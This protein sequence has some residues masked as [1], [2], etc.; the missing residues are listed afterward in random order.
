M[1]MKNFQQYKY[2]AALCF[3]GILTL[4]A[5]SP[6]HAEVVIKLGTLAPDGSPWHNLLKEMGEKWSQASEGQV[7]LKIYPGGIA[8]NESDMVRKL[9]VGQMQ[10]AMIT[11]VG[12]GDIH[13]AVKALSVPM[14][15]RDIQELDYVVSK[16]AP[17]LEQN[18]AEKGFVVLNWGDAGWVKFFTQKPVKTPD[19]MKGIKVFAWAGDE[20]AVEAW[21]I[22]GFTPVVI[23]STDITTSLQTGMLEAIDTTPLAALS[24]QW[25][26][27]AKYM[28]DI[29]WA[30]LAGATLISKQ[31]WDKIPEALRPKLLEIARETG[32]RVKSEARKMESNAIATMKKNGLEVL[33][34]SP[35][36]QEEWRKA[37]QKAY[38]YIKQKVVPADMFDAVSK[39]RDE[40]RAGK[41]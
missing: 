28:T 29:N 4:L 9:R 31:A 26:K 1:M 15:L 10:A 2:L 11:S 22:C 7:K 23:S 27:Y 39:L 40:Y 24:F 12:I 3:F 41:R 36:E 8:G 19:Q 35:A 6:G 16:L 17:K 37:A 34:L 25:F 21:K 18:L 5:P 32:M 13:P 38:P 33:S 14:L 20:S 30:P